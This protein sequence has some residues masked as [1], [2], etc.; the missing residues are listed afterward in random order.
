[1]SQILAPF[2]EE[3]VQPGFE[4][5]DRVAGDPRPDASFSPGL[6]GCAE[7]ITSRSQSEFLTRVS[8]E[9]S[10]YCLKNSAVM[11]A[12]RRDDTGGIRK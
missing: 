9:D 1:M 2:A 11:N 3:L 4:G 5:N 7:A 8:A 6:C 12:H 10:K